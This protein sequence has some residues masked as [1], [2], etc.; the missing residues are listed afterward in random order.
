MFSDGF[1]GPCE[2]MFNPQMGFTS[3]VENNCDPAPSVELEL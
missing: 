2:G 1:G 3:Q